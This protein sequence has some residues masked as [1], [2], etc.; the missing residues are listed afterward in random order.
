MQSFCRAS[1]NIQHQ[2]FLL[3][4]SPPLFLYP[5]Y[6]KINN[7]KYGLVNLHLQLLRSLTLTIDQPTNA[8]LVQI[9]NNN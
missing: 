5:L 4:T 9:Q 7:F 1:H 2:Q 6:R 8:Y 3:E